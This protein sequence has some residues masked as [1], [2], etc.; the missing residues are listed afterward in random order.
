MGMKEGSSTARV[1]QLRD[2]RRRG[3]RCLVTVEVTET[4]L[5]NLVRR[6]LLAPGRDGRTTRN[7]IAEAIEGAACG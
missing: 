3:V 1:Q 6:G 7:D 4:M 5:Q 2:R